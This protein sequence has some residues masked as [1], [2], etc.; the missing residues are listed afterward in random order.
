VVPSQVLL[1]AMQLDEEGITS[2]R[3]PMRMEI[4]PNQM[5]EAASYDHPQQ[6]DA[7]DRC[8]AVQLW[9]PRIQIRRTRAAVVICPLRKVWQVS[10]PSSY[11]FSKT[12]T[13]RMKFIQV[14]KLQHSGG[15]SLAQAMSS[16]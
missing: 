12:T 4:A 14:I 7:M 1:L 8:Q 2:S 3:H 9:E 5:F 15:I 10:N 11:H 16:R 6:D 13:P